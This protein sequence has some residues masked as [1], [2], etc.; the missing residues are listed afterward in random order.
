[1]S[2]LQLADFPHS[3]DEGEE[4]ISCQ[5]GFTL[6]ELLI[7]VAVIAILAAI[8][9]PTLVGAR[10]R[11]LYAQFQGNAHQIGVAL[12]NYAI[13][14]GGKY[15]RDGMFFGPPPD[16]FAPGYVNWNQGWQIDYEVHDNGSGGQY[17]GLEYFY[18]G[19]GYQALC[20]NA[21]NRVSYSHG[22]AIAGTKNRMW[23]FHE[24]AEIMP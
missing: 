6:V 19:E 18:P 3:R 2:D 20:N 10:Q 22:E 24:S 16:G 17:V 13:D 9:I 7:A 8:A 15:P 4:M 21:A 1:M 11:S 14:H 12:E 23:I 5:K